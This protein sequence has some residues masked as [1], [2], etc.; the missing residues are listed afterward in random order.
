MSNC[1]VLIRDSLKIL[2]FFRN[3]KANKKNIITIYVKKCL[4]SLKLENED[5]SGDYVY[6]LSENL[7]IYTVSLLAYTGLQCACFKD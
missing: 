7:Y 5:M 3:L 1:I 4:T 6:Q 2:H